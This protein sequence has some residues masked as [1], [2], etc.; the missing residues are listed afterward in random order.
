[1][2]YGGLI[3]RLPIHLIDAK[4]LEVSP[5]V[6]VV[7]GEPIVQIDGLLHSFSQLESNRIKTSIA[8]SIV[9]VPALDLWSFGS[10]EKE[11]QSNNHAHNGY[12]I[13]IWM[14]L[15]TEYRMTLLRV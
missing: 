11:D 7:V 9:I 8:I 15:S 5:M 3:D 6:L 10:S 13:E 4:V 12:P 1:M 2:G 14:I